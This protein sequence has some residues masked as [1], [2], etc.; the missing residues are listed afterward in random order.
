MKQ[1]RTG[2]RVAPWFGRDTGGA[3]AI[4]R[5]ARPRGD[6]FRVRVAFPLEPE[7]EL[8]TRGGWRAQRGRIRRRARDGAGEAELVTRVI[9]ELE[10][11]IPVSVVTSRF[12]GTRRAARKLR[13]SASNRQLCARR[14]LS[15]PLARQ[16][17]C[18]HVVE[19]P[20]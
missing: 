15:E 17:E 4:Q 14:L 6:R 13:R 10:M 1:D 3:R 8:I 18:T 20:R 7:L 11:R 5:P 12:P 19:D 16:L 9:P 2:V